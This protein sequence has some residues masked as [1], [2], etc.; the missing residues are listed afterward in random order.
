MELQ[1]LGIHNYE[2]RDSRMASYVVDGRLVL[3]AG[4]LTRALTFEQQS[5]VEAIVLSHRH[6]DHTRDLVTFG[7]FARKSGMTVDIYGI[8]DTLNDVQNFLLHPRKG[9]DFVKDS[10]YRLN[11]V[12]PYKEF[13]VLDYR[14][15]AVPVFH[16]VPAA[17]YLVS[18]GRVGLFYT[19]DTGAEIGRFWEHVEADVL[20]TEVTFGNENE[21]VAL[22][23][24]HLTPSLLGQTLNEYREKHG[25]MPRVVVSH[26]N[27]PWEEAVRRELGD[28]ARQTGAD[29]QVAEP[30]QV[31]TLAARQQG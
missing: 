20:L 8:G 23:V 6:F 1:V 24:G 3:D 11:E 29:I 21:S 15:T 7:M 27:P 9:P 12:E 22:E 19:G 5:R 14:V 28:V 26:I 2:S 31:L 10:V 18:N 17:G 25:Y 13:R 30:D 4:S 16:A